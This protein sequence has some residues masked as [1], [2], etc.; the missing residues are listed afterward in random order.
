M[1]PR[2][3]RVDLDRLAAELDAVLQAAADGSLYERRRSTRCRPTIAASATSR[4]PATASRPTFPQLRRGGRGRGGAAPALRPRRH[5]DRPASP[6]R[7][8]SRSRPCARRSTVLDANNGEIWAKL[9]AGTRGVL[10]TDRP[11]E[12]LA[13]AGAREHPRRGAGAARRHPVAVHAGE[14]RAAPEAEVQAYCDRLNELR[15]PAARLKGIQLYTIARKPAEA[16][17]HAAGRRGTGRGRGRSS[18]PA[19]RR[20]SKCSTGST[21][22]DGRHLAIVYGAIVYLAMVYVAMSIQ[23]RAS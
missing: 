4:S 8:T 17:R 12:R 10:P 21:G 3:R 2:V 6:T 9:D 13:P 11:A 19:S 18:A 15:A 16:A 14:R 22:R 20:R 5:E 7:P 23:F 1:P